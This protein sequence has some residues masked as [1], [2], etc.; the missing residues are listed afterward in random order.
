MFLWPQSTEFRRLNLSKFVLTVL[1][2]GP[3]KKKVPM[4]FCNLSTKSFYNYL[5]PAIDGK[6]RSAASQFFTFSRHI[7][8]IWKDT[9]PLKG[10]VCFTQ[11]LPIVLTMFVHV[12]ER[13]SFSFTK[14]QQ[15]CRK[16]RLKYWNFL[17]CTEIG[18]FEKVV[19]RV[20]GVLFIEQSVKYICYCSL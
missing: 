1:R 7:Y 19:S 13:E 16:M 14:L 11:R 18:S 3:L 2:E 9:L 20:Q 15:I 12:F 17:E 10:D 4:F 8:K 5:L 6:Y